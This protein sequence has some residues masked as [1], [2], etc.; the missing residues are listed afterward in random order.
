MEMPNVSTES[1]LLLK[2]TRLYSGTDGESHF[3]DL[4]PLPLTPRSSGLHNNVS[5]ALDVQQVFFHTYTEQYFNDWHSEE[6]RYAILFLT[7]EQEVEVGDGTKRRF[8]SGDLLIAEDLKGRGHR[9]R[10]IM[11]GQSLVCVLQESTFQK[12]VVGIE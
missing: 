1:K 11:P 10:G 7:G 5:E 8:R 2:I 12:K 6:K 3:E 9:T 4:P